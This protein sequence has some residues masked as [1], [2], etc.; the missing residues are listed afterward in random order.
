MDDLIE[1]LREVVTNRPD[2]LGICTAWLRNPDGPEAADRIAALEAENALMRKA[3]EEIAD[4]IPP[5]SVIIAKS[6]LAKL[7]EATDA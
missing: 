7:K 6:T 5:V 1:R 4:P 3:L 2:S